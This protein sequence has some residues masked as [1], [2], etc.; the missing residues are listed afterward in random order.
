MT[1]LEKFCGYSAF[2]LDTMALVNIQ[3]VC[4]AVT[5][6]SRQ[7]TVKTKILYICHYCKKKVH[8]AWMCH[9]KSRRSQSKATSADEAVTIL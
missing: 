3:I 5:K 4:V 1:I 9:S 8:F 7:Q 2:L 6:C